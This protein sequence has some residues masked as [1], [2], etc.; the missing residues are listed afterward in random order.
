MIKLIE[1]L[2]FKKVT[3]GILVIIL[4]WLGYNVL[5]DYLKYQETKKDGNICKEY[6]SKFPNGW[7]TEQVKIIE[8][9]TSND[10]V[11]ARAFLSEYPESKYLKEVSDFGENLW[12]IEIAR[13]DSLVTNNDNYDPEAV[14]FFRTLLDYMKQ[15]N[16]ST[17]YFYLNGSVEVKNWE[18]YTEEV[19]SYL[20][21]AYST[22]EGITYGR[23]VDGNILNI[24]SNYSEGNIITYE[25]ILNQSINDSFEQILS[26][27]FIQIKTID[28]QQSEILTDV[29]LISINYTIKNQ[30]DEWLEGIDAP[31][32]WTYETTDFSTNRAIFEAYIIGVEISFDFTFKLPDEATEFKFESTSNA[33]DDIENISDISDGYAKMTQQSFENYANE[34]LTKFGLNDTSKLDEWSEL[35]YSY[36][37]YLLYDEEKSISQ[38]SDTLISYGYSQEDANLII[39]NITTYYNSLAQ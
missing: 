13:Y 29:L 23:E 15:N 8:I 3:I 16:Q 12:E 4:F 36:A 28:E 30:R 26:D 37:I 10:I 7:F 25:E 27:N 34:I 19:K 14:N 9:K 24:T 32:L 17:I 6:Y 31:Y 18:D 2:T 11:L 21:Y 38:V 5:I 39:E 22:A 1:R 20:N 33:F 35:V